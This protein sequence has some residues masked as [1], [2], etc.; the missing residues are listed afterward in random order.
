VEVDAI[1]EKLFN[2]NRQTVKGLFSRTNFKGGATSL[3]LL[4]SHHWPG[5]ALSFL[6]MLLS[7]EG[8]TACQKCFAADDAPEP[9]HNWNATPSVSLSCTYVPP[10]LCKNNNSFDANGDKPPTLVSS[11]NDSS[12]GWDYYDL[13][14]DPCKGDGGELEKD[15]SSDDEEEIDRKKNE[16]NGKKIEKKACPLK[17]SYHQFVS[18][19]QELLTFHSWWCHGPPPFNHSPMQEEVDAV[20]L[21]IQKMIARIITFCP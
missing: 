3:T 5:M 6:M 21:R 12:N 8:K 16:K 13:E 20:H 1:I 18:L 17:C 14:T 11:E 7:E 9:P 10:I 2:G 4:S 15:S 19:L